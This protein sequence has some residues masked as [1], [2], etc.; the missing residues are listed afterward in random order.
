[1]REKIYSPALKLVLLHSP[2][3][4]LNFGRYFV[5]ISSTVAKIQAQTFIGQLLNCVCAIRRSSFRTLKVR[6]QR[7][8]RNRLFANF[9]MVFTAFTVLFFEHCKL[10]CVD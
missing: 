9:E 7:Y 4:F 6:L 2:F 1:M 8:G 10:F 5:L 3:Y